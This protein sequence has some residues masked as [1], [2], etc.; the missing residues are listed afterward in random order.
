MDKKI[1]ARWVKALRSGRYQQGTGQLRSGENFCC[2]GVL[3]DLYVKSKKR[4]WVKHP[5]DPETMLLK[6]SKE[7]DVLP[8][9]VAEWAGLGRNNRDPEVTNGSYSTYLSTLNDTGYSFEKI[10]KLIEKQL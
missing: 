10:S 9:A 7:A 3:C 1:K 6:G 8:R 4:S 2:L 5:Q